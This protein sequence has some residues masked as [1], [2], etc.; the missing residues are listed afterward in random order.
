MSAVIQ[1]IT[2]SRARDM[3]G[4][5]TAAGERLEA[6]EDP[7]WFEVAR[8]AAFLEGLRLGLIKVECYGQEKAEVAHA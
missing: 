2:Q 7:A 6:M 5:L 1:T 8:A 4:R 3:V